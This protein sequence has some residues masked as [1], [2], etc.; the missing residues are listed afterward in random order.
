MEKSASF[1]LRVGLALMLAIGGL[2]FSWI[3]SGILH[4][5]TSAGACCTGA[6]YGSNATYVDNAV[7][8]IYPE[9]QNSGE[10]PTCN[11]GVMTT[12]AIANYADQ[13]YYG[14]NGHNQFPNQASQNTVDT[15]NQWVSSQSQWGTPVTASTISACGGL[16]NISLDTGTDPRTIAYDTYLYS[17]PGYYFGNVL[18]RSDLVADHPTNYSLQVAEATTMMAQAIETDQT[19]LS[20]AING[21]LHSVLVTGIYANNDP[22]S[23]WPASISGIVYRDPQ[24]KASASRFTV[25]YSAW[26]TYGLNPYGG[27]YHYSLWSVYYGDV[28]TIGDQANTSDPEPLVGPYAPNAGAGYPYHWYHGFDWIQRIGGNGIV[29][30]PGPDYAFIGPYTYAGQQHPMALLTHP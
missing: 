4:D 22:A 23:N 7:N 8:A 26:A 10:G 15:L 16:A 24:Y 19:P 29:S 30:G 13:V 25:D 12:M 27:S 21:G 1:P 17:P 9:W 6:F 28:N 2:V 5:A 18:Y 3:I 20:V 14:N 11:C